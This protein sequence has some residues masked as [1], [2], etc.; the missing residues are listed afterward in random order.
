MVALVINGSEI[1]V[2]RRVRFVEELQQ[3]GTLAFRASDV[4]SAAEYFADGILVL[5]HCHGHD[6]DSTMPL[7]LSLN[8]DAAQCYIE[9]REWQK[10]ID[11][12]NAVLD[13]DAANQEALSRKATALKA[14]SDV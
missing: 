9:M 5:S 6:Q 10:V 7:V 12:C 13:V 3:L 11:H 8:L 14:L 4:S 2:E 1:P